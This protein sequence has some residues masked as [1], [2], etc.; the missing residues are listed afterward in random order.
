MKSKYIIDPNGRYD[1][2]VGS[3]IRYGIGLPLLG[4]LLWVALSMCSCKTQ[5]PI[6]TETNTNTLIEREQV[7]SLIKVAADRARAQLALECDSLGNVHIRELNTLQGERTRLEIALRAALEAANQQ[8]QQTQPNQP[9]KPAQNPV[10][11]LDVDCKADSLQILVNKLRERIREYESSNHTETVTVEVVPPYYQ[12]TSKGFWVL[13]AILVL[14]V[15]WKI[16]KAYFK[17]QTGGMGSIL[18]KFL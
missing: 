3:V 1:S 9:A 2:V 15:G 13:L 14:I 5:Q 4:V 11:L 18:S 10:F 7:D 12:N 16:A 8:Q 6:V 17:I